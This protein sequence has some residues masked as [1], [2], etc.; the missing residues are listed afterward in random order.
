MDGDF[1]SKYLAAEKAYGA[2]DFEAAQ[3]ITLELLSQLEPIPEE[4]AERDAV[5]AWRAFVA[6]LAG[7]IDLYGFQE[8]AQARK[9]YQL[10]LASN[11]QD[12]LRELAEQGLERTR[13]T[14]ELVTGSEQV[15]DQGEDQCTQP[16]QTTG[17]LALIA[18]PFLSAASAEEDSLQPTVIA[19]AMP[20]LKDEQIVDSH[21]QTPS[22]QINALAE[23]EPE[24][25]AQPITELEP[26]PEPEPETTSTITEIS[27]VI[28]DEPSDSILDQTPSNQINALAEPEPEAEAQSITELEPE[29]DCES[30]PSG[31]LAHGTT[32]EVVPI[33]TKPKADPEINEAFIKR[34]EAGNL[35]VKLPDTALVEPTKKSSVGDQPKSRWSWLRTALRSR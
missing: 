21:D 24:A 35:L 23:P 14:P 7:H 3:S 5:L 25:E 29:P 1:Q 30:E 28:N 11:P 20:W 9:F 32:I 31:E 13:G 34:L 19:T 6:L 18:D 16:A 2:G 12:T 27:T 4:G 26:E 15:I 33:A 8:P 17:S 10:V 22:N